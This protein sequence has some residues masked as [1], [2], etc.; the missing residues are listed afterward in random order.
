VPDSARQCPT[1]PD[2][3]TTF[4]SIDARIFCDGVA[5]S[6]RKDSVNSSRVPIGPPGL[7]GTPSPSLCAVTF[8]HSQT[9]HF[10]RQSRQRAAY[11]ELRCHE[12][13]VGVSDNGS[14]EEVGI[15]AGQI[16]A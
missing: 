10:Q 6:G 7:P 12:R 13:A 9:R 3:M 8:G 14:T 2:N 5:V 15:L 16:I 11:A 1:V 4:W